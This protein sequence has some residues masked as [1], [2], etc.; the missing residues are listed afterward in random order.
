[1]DNLPIQDLVFDDKGNMDGTRF[2]VH[3][4]NV[5][6]GGFVRYNRCKYFIKGLILWE[7]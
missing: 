6:I 4:E 3:V 5:E 2:S 1:M 7:R